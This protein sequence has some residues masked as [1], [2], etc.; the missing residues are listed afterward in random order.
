MKSKDFLSLNQSQRDVMRRALWERFQLNVE[1]RR[2]GTSA[3]SSLLGYAAV[4][5]ESL[6]SHLHAY[7]SVCK[8]GRGKEKWLGTPDIKGFFFMKSPRDGEVSV[9][10]GLLAAG[11]LREGRGVARPA[12]KHI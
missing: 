11:M 7:G 10:L 9:L 6:H 3:T 8:T 12:G 2:R 4:Q 1:W 5:P